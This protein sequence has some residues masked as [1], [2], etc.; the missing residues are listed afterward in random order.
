MSEGD[1]QGASGSSLRSSKRM[2]LS[3]LNADQCSLKDLEDRFGSFG[4]SVTD[5]HNWPPLPNAVD[6]PTDWC[7]L[8]LT[9]EES[10][11]RRAVDLLHGTLWKGKKLRISKAKER[12]WQAIDESADKEKKK[13]KKKSKGIEGIES[14]TLN[15]PITAKDVEKGEWGWKKT[16][17]GHLIRPMHMRPDH[18]L[19]KPTI[20]KTDEETKD[21]KKRKR[22]QE[23]VPRPLTRAKRITIDPSRYGAVHLSKMM[24]E[25]PTV[26]AVPG[27]SW[28]YEEDESDGNAI[29]TLKDEEGNVLRT[30][31]VVIR[32]PNANSYSASDDEYSASSSQPD[33]EEENDDI[34]DEIDAAIDQ[35]SDMS[36]SEE[37][38]VIAEEDVVEDEPE[39]NLHSDAVGEE[40][41]QITYPHYDPDEEDAFSDG[42]QEMTSEKFSET[43]VD[44]GL[45]SKK[46]LDI[47]KRMFGEGALRADRPER[48][49][50]V[51]PLLDDDDES[52]EDADA[53]ENTQSQD[54][55]PELHKQPSQPPHKVQES[56]D[57]ESDSSDSTDEESSPVPD[58]SK[59]ADS[60][61]QDVREPEEDQ[62]AIEGDRVEMKTL[63]D[64]FR[65]KE[66]KGGFSIMADLDLDLDEEF[67]FE[68]DI[69]DGE[70]DFV[71]DNT[72]RTQDFTPSYTTVPQT[73]K[74]QVAVF[75]SLDADGAIR[76]NGNDFI[77]TLA[78]Q[79]RQKDPSMTA[80]FQFDDPETISKKW[81]E[82]KSTLTQVYKRRHRE[83][84]KKKKRKYTG[85]RA[86]G[87]ALPGRRVM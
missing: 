32:Q 22:K 19:P 61:M 29:W 20:V 25:D 21:S 1:T 56:S 3:G 18:P 9:G 85:S 46:Q 4:L 87:T 84:L 34:F 41:M 68:P 60:E 63:T 77:S 86:A 62:S 73:A 76:T 37:D 48:A 30:E 49:H 36:D 28:S 5:V 53:E 45:E 16:P 67:N 24:L 66:V 55:E 59:P 23:T 58:S 40:T 50:G 72:M 17:A 44:H 51:I 12:A 35:A 39:E 11:I 69:E 52:G 10:K 71:Q 54:D 81:E 57:S 83:A 27:Q 14:E 26:E 7:F 13:K 70:A 33:E 65:P 15:T 47:L 80:F 64:M 6:Q 42:Y 8:T 43:K 74:K 75:P 78:R 38:N 79:L 31:Q 82:R 2:H